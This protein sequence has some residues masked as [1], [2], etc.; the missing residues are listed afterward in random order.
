MANFS[1]LDEHRISEILNFYGLAPTGTE[2]IDGGLANTSHRVSTIDG[3]D[4]VV[5][6]CDYHDL[7]SA[8]RLTE[9]IGGLQGRCYAPPPALVGSA[10]SVV[11]VDSKPVIVKPYIHGSCFT[12]IATA[13]LHRL[14]SILADIHLTPVPEAGLGSRNRRLK[15]GW[16]TDADCDIELLDA[17]AS[18]EHLMADPFLEA[19]PSGLT[20]GDLFPDNVVWPAM[21]HPVVIDWESASVDLFVYDL[22]ITLVANCINNDGT[23]DP[24]RA[25]RLLAGYLT[26]RPLTDAER[27]AIDPCARYASAF[28]A[29]SRARRRSLYPDLVVPD[30]EHFL[31][32]ATEGLGDI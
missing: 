7:A 30:F 11:V 20:H 12:R 27:T 32:V 6:V 1:V 8:L 10:G 23:T 2:L 26:K 16:A 15:P 29:L 9:V 18:A 31:R 28:I 24:I 14:G 13:G 3:P 22:A 21:G 19:L 4:V 17:V 5:T 25:S